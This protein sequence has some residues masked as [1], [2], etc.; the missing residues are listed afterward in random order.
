MFSK[1]KPVYACPG[2]A[3]LNSSVSLGRAG[4]EVSYISEF[5]RDKVGDIILEFLM[6]NNVSTESLYL[7]EGSS[8]LALAFLNEKNDAKYHFYENFPEKRLYIDVPDFAPDD[9]VMFGS[10]L[11]VTRQARDKLM[12][13]L[14]S[15]GIAGS[16]L[17]YD[18][19]YRDSLFCP[20][21][22]IEPLIS[23]NIALADIVRASDEDMR[24]IS[25]CTSP[26]EAYEFV[27][28]RGCDVLIYTANSQGVYLRTPSYSREYT[29]PEIETVS[30]VGAG[31]TF[32][33]GIVYMLHK[34]KITDLHNVSGSQW[35]EIINIAIEFASHVCMSNDNYISP[36]FAD[37]LKKI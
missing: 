7:Y 10:I 15:A 31:D 17:Y 12:E 35:D 2:G 25:E 36:G 11:S 30:T 5:A 24:K 29:V 20:I 1:G 27:C 16:L 34:R 9:I 13:V 33:A 3:M 18:P 6:D 21:E 26:D 28:Q 14:N 37:R 32:N 19:N 4:V 23:E 8:P 22:Y